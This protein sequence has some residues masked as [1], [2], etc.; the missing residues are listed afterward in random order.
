[1]R[2]T[3]A[4]EAA[5]TVGKGEIV[6]GH[7]AAV[8]G[9]RPRAEERGE[10]ELQR[11]NKSEDCRTEEP[12]DGRCK[13]QEHRRRGRSVDQ[14]TFDGELRGQ[15][16]R[17]RAGTDGLRG[18]LRGFIGNSGHFDSVQLISGGRAGAAAGAV[19]FGGIAGGG[20]T[21]TG[22]AGASGNRR[23]GC[24]GRWRRRSGN[25]RHGRG[26]RWSGS[27]GIV[28]MNHL[29]ALRSRGKRERRR[30][31]GLWIDNQRGHCGRDFHFEFW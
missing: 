5:P 30:F 23:H 24:G 13:E 11:R 8:R 4:S 9:H 1:M 18:R 25:R 19:A 12:R 27:E 6:G 28:K 26:G 2:H 20:G 10:V 22:G 16:A 21:G 3:H 14:R 15:I 29:C 31:R 7:N 17:A